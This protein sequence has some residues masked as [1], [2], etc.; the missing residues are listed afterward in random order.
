V[1][2][3]TTL[4]YSSPN[5]SLNSRPLNRL[6]TLCSRQKSQLLWNQANPASFPKMP[7]CGVGHPECNYGTPGVGYTLTSRPCEISKL[8]PLFSRSSCNLVNAILAEPLHLSPSLSP[9]CSDLSAL[10]VKLFLALA[11]RQAPLTPFRINTCK[12]VSKQTT[13]TPF[14]ITTYEKPRG[15]GY[16]SSSPCPPCS[17]LHA[18]CVKPPPAFADVPNCPLH[19]YYGME[20]NWI[21]R[22]ASQSPQSTQPA[23]K[24]LS[25]TEWHSVQDQRMT[26]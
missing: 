4:S 6:Q 2:S 19:D 1:L 10:C 16:I 12:S 18:L 24:G 20:E 9:L 25:Q 15:R 7:G 13:L 5:D 21:P 22:R 8:Q 26:S 14:R 23:G 11:G 17:D 3:R